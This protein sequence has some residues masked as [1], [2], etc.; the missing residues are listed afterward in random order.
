[1]IKIG[2]LS[3]AVTSIAAVLFF[4]LTPVPPLAAAENSLNLPPA[5]FNPPAVGTKIAWKK[6]SFDKTSELIVTGTSGFRLNYTWDGSDSSGYV[7]CWNC[8]ARG[9][10]VINVK[11]YATLWPLT[12][13]K[14]ATFDRVSGRGSWTN[15]IT[16]AGT[17]KLKTPFGLVDTYRVVNESRSHNSDWEGTREYWYAPS[18]GYMVKSKT[19][20][21]R[22]DDYEWEVTG[23]TKQ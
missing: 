17:E 7:N 16:V 11:A 14:T 1:M 6:V 20:D 19:T 12:V 18:I 3:G 9:G 22:G 8:G 5:P 13:G 2:F 23:V 15:T 10:T 21:N 4:L